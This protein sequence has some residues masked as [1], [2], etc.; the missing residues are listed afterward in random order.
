LNNIINLV[1]LN[2]ESFIT[3]ET[4]FIGFMNKLALHSSNPF[5]R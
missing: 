2:L 4:G 1:L 5:S 3:F